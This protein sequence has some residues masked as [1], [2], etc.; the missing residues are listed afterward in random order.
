[1]N[2]IT[3]AES[4]KLCIELWTLL[5]DREFY[6]GEWTLTR[7]SEKKAALR[8]IGYDPQDVLYACFA[9]EYSLQVVRS[10]YPNSAEIQR[11]CR[12]CPIKAWRSPDNPHATTCLDEGQP[13]FEW[14]EA[15]VV[16]DACTYAQDVVQLAQESLD[17][18]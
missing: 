16:E 18:L 1:M 15:T 9:C 6:S 14:R 12:F 4:L 11:D 5:S 13:Y 7:D 8:D 2:K 17:A 10:M 3:K